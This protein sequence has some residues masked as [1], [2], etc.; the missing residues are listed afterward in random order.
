VTAKGVRLPHVC[1]VG[2]QIV[3]SPDTGSELY[4]ETEKV[5]ALREQ[6]VLAVIQE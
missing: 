6:D 5:I 3:F 2:E 4:F 1:A